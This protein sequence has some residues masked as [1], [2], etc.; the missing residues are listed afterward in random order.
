[1]GAGDVVRANQNHP[2]AAALVT[3]LETPAV[4]PAS[5]LEQAR[6]RESLA[7][8]GAPLAG[9]RPVRRFGLEETALL[10]LE[11]SARDATVLRTLPVLL[12]RNWSVLNWAALKEEA[13]RRKLKAHLGMLAELTA[14]LAGLPGSPVKELRDRRVKRMRF[15]PEVKSRYEEELARR[16]TPEVA[17]RWGF[18]MN[19]SEE[20]FRR[21]LEQHRA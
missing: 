10:G 2:A 20:S 19:L 6:V 14:S 21:T 4:V 9:V 8:W 5:R 7:G 15:F 17:K 11:E 13:R 1:M 18:W 12:A 16:R 3:L